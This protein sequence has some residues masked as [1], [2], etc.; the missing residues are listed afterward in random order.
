M[1]GPDTMQSIAEAFRMGG[2]WMYAILGYFSI[3]LIFSPVDFKTSPSPTSTPPD[4][5][6]F[7]S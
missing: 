6:R 1:E 4:G 5:M 2:M 7:P 3:G